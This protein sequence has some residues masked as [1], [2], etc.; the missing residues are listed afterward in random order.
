MLTAST[1]MDSSDS[2]ELLPAERS[3]IKDLT[4]TVDELRGQLVDALKKACDYM[5]KAAE[6]AGQVEKATDIVTKMSDKL[7]EQVNTNLDLHRRV[8]S[9]ELE[10]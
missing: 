2:E 5:E 7:K 9:L 10:A 6:V 1:C 4:T 8:M 3:V